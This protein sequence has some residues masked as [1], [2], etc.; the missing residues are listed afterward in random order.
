MKL[1]IERF[2]TQ[3]NCDKQTVGFAFVFDENNK[4]VYKFFTLELPDFGNKKKVSNIPVGTYRVVK[5]YSP[6]YGNHFHILDVEGRSYILI[7]VGNYY[8][9]TE[10]CIL[11]GNDLT[12]INQDGLVDV[13]NSG[14]VMKKLNE[15][16]PDEF[17]LEIK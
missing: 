11:V 8:T 6:K 4:L 16:L 12:D 13:A 5:R 9:Q 17:E 3:Y 7:H 14:V 1:I 15:I 10:G 2:R